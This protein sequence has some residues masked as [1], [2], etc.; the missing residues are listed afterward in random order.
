M[1]TK[2]R[3]IIVKPNGTIKWGGD[4]IQ[5]MFVNFTRH[6]SQTPLPNE[7]K[8]WSKKDK[9]LWLMRFMPPSHKL[10]LL[11]EPKWTRKKLSKY[12]QLIT[13]SFESDIGGE[14]PPIMPPVRR[15]GRLNFDAF[16]LAI[17]NSIPPSPPVNYSMESVNTALGVSPWANLTDNER[18]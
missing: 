12:K 17:G 6:L 5:Y 1:A 8:K 11:R 7:W 15:T 10:I 14:M 2:L 18:R 3:I 4:A 9:M 16:N 13:E